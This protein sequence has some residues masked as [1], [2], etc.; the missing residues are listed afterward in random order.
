[1]NN[2]IEFYVL[3]DYFRIVADVDW[4]YNYTPDTKF[5]QGD[6]E[7]RRT[8]NEIAVFTEDRAGNEVAIYK[9][10]SITERSQHEVLDTLSRVLAGLLPV[11]GDDPAVQNFDLEIEI[12]DAVMVL[13]GKH[14]RP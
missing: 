12:D 3:S 9:R 1:M 10:D 11:L 7:L 13:V 4:D 6:F 8:V 14:G 2:T 5:A